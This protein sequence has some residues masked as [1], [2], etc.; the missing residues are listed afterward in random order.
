MQTVTHIPGP[1]AA[2]F[3]PRSKQE[4]I[5]P[6]SSEAVC[7]I[8][9]EAID[10]QEFA[11]SILHPVH[12]KSAYQVGHL[13][14]LKLNQTANESAAGHTADNISWISEHGNRIQGSLSLNKTRDLLS[15]I[16]QNYERAGLTHRSVTLP[17]AALAEQPAV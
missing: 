11:A 6:L 17:A 16:A 2:T 13:N 9:L 5:Q 12:G 10:F 15:K 8:T 14:P 7:P 4:L 3:L 1:V